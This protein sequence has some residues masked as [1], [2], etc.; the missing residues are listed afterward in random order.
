MSKKIIRGKNCSRLRGSLKNFFPQKSYFLPNMM[1]SGTSELV[2]EIKQNTSS[3][4]FR[5]AMVPEMDAGR[6]MRASGFCGT[7]ETLICGTRVHV[8]R[9][10]NARG[11][12]TKVFANVCV[13]H[14]VASFRND[15]SPRTSW[16]ERRNG[17]E[18]SF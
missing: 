9:R 12:G 2:H 8:P 4:G 10:I 6:C 16:R 5:A 7:R 15:T 18:G 1:C 14:N 11:F 13:R 17:T 3:F